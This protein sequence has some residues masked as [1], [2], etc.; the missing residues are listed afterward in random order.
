MRRRS[1]RRWA[2]RADTTSPAQA[3]T[4]ASRRGCRTNSPDPPLIA[5]KGWV[6]KSALAPVTRRAS[7]PLSSHPAAVM[8]V[9]AIAQQPVRDG[10]MRQPHAEA[11]ARARSGGTGSV[12]RESHPYGAFDGPHSP[13]RSWA[14]LLRCASCSSERGSTSDGC[15]SSRGSPARSVAGSC[16]R[17]KQRVL[18]RGH[19]ASASGRR[20]GGPLPARREIEEWRST[21]P[22]LSVAVDALARVPLPT[23]E[24]ERIERQRASEHR[25]EKRFCASTVGCQQAERQESQKRQ[26]PAS[27]RG[28]R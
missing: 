9:S 25:T 6:A 22:D 11:Q 7:V 28:S 13:R 1:R 17:A 18:G 23:H 27:K 21:R 12:G 16:S 20:A 10:F 2:G 26:S 8:A 14:A 24:L 4:T 19:R 5:S 3:Q 15:F